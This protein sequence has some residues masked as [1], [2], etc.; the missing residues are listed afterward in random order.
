MLDWG[1]TTLRR[2]EREIA[3]SIARLETKLGRK[4]QEEEIAS[5]LGL[6]L[7]KLHNAMAQIDSLC[8]VGQQGNSGRECEGVEDLIESA[9]SSEDDNPLKRCAD[10]EIKDHLARAFFNLS[11]RQRLIISLHYREE[12]TMAQIAETLGISVPRVSQIHAVALAKLR[13]SLAHLGQSKEAGNKR[14]LA[15]NSELR[16]A[17]G[18]RK[19]TFTATPGRVRLAS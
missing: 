14:V 15:E 9:P 18:P 11:E 13:S 10:A 8:V 6:S 4:P 2:K 3:G 5:D 17:N 16:R 19:P 12:F 7:H 1:T